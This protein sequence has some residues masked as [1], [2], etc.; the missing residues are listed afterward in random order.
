M[1]M[2]IEKLRGALLCISLCASTTLLPSAAQA[3]ACLARILEH[4]SQFVKEDLYDKAP[5]YLKAVP[6]IVSAPKPNIWTKIGNFFW[7]QPERLELIEQDETPKDLSAESI[8][9]IVQEYNDH[10]L[11]LRCH[12]AMDVEEKEKSAFHSNHQAALALKAFTVTHQR[13]RDYVIMKKKNQNDLE[14]IKSKRQSV[15]SRYTSATCFLGTIATGK[16]FWRLLHH[17]N[18]PYALPASIALG[19]ITGLLLL[20]AKIKI[21]RCDVIGKSNALNE[22]LLEKC[23]KKLS[24][25]CFYTD[26]LLH[27]IVANN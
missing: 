26:H 3:S 20:I 12:D 13:H 21:D 18:I 24:N 11:E 6:K 1:K 8:D 14:N 19:S 7:P 2:N 17:I 5:A 10:P 23:Q 9:T 16:S 22:H 27:N 25:G 4:N 15:L